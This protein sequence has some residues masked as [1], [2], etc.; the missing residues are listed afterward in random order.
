MQVLCISKRRKTERRV[1]AMDPAIEVRNY[2]TSALSLKVICKMRRV[3][4]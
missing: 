1:Q 3:K 2:I 4:R